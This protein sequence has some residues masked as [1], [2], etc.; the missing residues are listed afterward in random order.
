MEGTSPDKP[1]VMAGSHIDT[2]PHGGMFDGLVGTIG[3]LEAIRVISEEGINPTH[4]VELV[5]FSEEEG[6]NFGSTTAGSKAMVGKYGVED[7]KKLKNPEGLSMYE[8]AKNAGYDPDALPGQTLKK[9]EVKAMLELHIEQSVVLDS[10]GIPIGVVEAIAGINAFE[11]EFTGVANHAGATPMHLRKDALVAAAKVISKVESLARSTASPSTVGTVG[12][13]FCEP[14]VS[15]VIPGKVRFTLDAR[16][17][18][19]EGIEELVGNVR[20]AVE[21]EA[22]AG[23]LEAKMRFVGGSDPI[24]LPEDMV[25][26]IEE[27]AKG[28]GVKYRR[29]NSGAVHDACLLAKITKIGMIFVPSI[30]GRSHVP[31]EN[32]RFEDIQLGCDLLLESILKLAR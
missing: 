31:E 26:L 28:M 22:A 3:A 21:A 8:A 2:V 18:D 24:I 15:N 17:V 10:E 4:P 9:E 25:D 13:I 27:T 12:R 14:N 30:N 1:V 20:K 6:S 32:T 11:I 23:G 5:I 19:P 29:M 7:L 16:D